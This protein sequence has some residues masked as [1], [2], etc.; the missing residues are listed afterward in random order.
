MFKRSRFSAKYHEN[1]FVVGLPETDEKGACVTAKRLT[2]SI[3][4]HALSGLISDIK[5]EPVVGIS[6]LGKM[7][8]FQQICTLI[9]KR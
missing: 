8:K 2:R 4:E 7:L 1:Y 5:L 9:Q 3:G 6:T